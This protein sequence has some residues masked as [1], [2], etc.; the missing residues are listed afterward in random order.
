MKLYQSRALLVSL[1]SLSAIATAAAQGPRG[2]RGGPPPGPPPQTGMYTTVSGAITQ[3]NY[4]R[5]AEIEGFLLNNDTLVHLPP[6][7][8]PRIGV[9]I[10]ARDN[11]QISGYEQ[12]SATGF[13]TI[14]AQA[15]EDRT[16]GKSFTVPQPGASAPYSC[17]GRIQQLNYGP[18]GA[19][20][21]FLLDNGTLAAVPAFAA[22]NPSSI[23]A[24]ATV[25]YTGYARSTLAGRT[26]VDVQS[27]TINGQSLIVN[28]STSGGPAGAGPVPPGRTDEPPPP[29][30]PGTPPQL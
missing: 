5:D 18:D 28:P 19:I 21:G 8:A 10:H 16:S 27:L 30:P 1:V 23:H 20:N 14:E 12:T 17:S 24:G 22:T 13:K 6:Q 29:P 26:V 3:F 11:V 7:A 15:I 2:R 9:S 4:N 25:A